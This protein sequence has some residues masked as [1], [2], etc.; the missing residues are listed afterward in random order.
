M[1]SI[2]TRVRGYEEE[3]WADPVQPQLQESGG[4]EGAA[5]PQPIQTPASEEVKV[6]D[7]VITPSETGI[8][9]EEVKEAKPAETVE[10]KPDVQSV[11][12]PTPNGIQLVEDKA[13]ETG[14]WAQREQE[15]LKKI[16][17][18]EKVKS[19]RT[20]DGFKLEL[21][22]R[23]EEIDLLKARVKNL[24]TEL[25]AALSK[26]TGK[27]HEMI[28]NIKQQHEELLS[29]ARGM[30]FDKTKM[31]KN[32][33]L[34]IEALTTQVQSLKDINVITKDLLEIRNSEVKA[35]EDRL[36]AME[37]R[38]KAEKDRYGLVLQRAQTSTTLN[39]DL[40]KEYETQLAIFKELRQKYEQ[41]VQALVAENA[42]LKELAD[43]KAKNNTAAGAGTSG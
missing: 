13:K 41:R 42:K 11:P 16:E 8:K 1:R 4:G 33:E 23:E 35:M 18:L 10:V 24:E 9:S 40:K 26:P 15:L 6:A 36:Q 19:E 5:A 3:T 17:E 30:I 31:V 37:A 38:F 28:E 43:Y 25:Q 20:E 14:D 12:Q 22:V 34:Q 7:P 21:K 32:Q 27:N 39:D 2:W 29:K